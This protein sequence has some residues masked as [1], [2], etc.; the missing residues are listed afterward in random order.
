MIS[1]THKIGATTFVV[2]QVRSF[3]KYLWLK[4]LLALTHLRKY[5]SGID[6]IVYTR[7]DLSQ[8]QQQ[9]HSQQHHQSG[10]R[11]IPEVKGLPLVGTLFDLLAAGAAPKLHI[12]ID[13]RHGQYGDIFRERLGGTQDAIFVSSANLMRSVF[14]HEG[15]YPKHPLPDAWILYNQKHNC[16]RGLFFME[17]EEW[18]HNRRLLSRVLL[19]GH[20]NWMDWHVR[21]CTNR[22]ITKWKDDLANVKHSSGY[23]CMVIDNLEQQLYRWSIDVVIS[24]M[25]GSVA[26]EKA[27][28]T[29]HLAVTDFSKVVHKIFESSS[30]LMN[31]P[32][33][34][35]EYFRLKIWTDF[36][37][38]VEQAL[39]KGC[40]IIDMYLD[41][42][43]E[44]P[45]GL[46]AKL[47]EADTPMDMIK[48]LFVDLVIAAGDT[49]AYSSAWALYLLSKDSK[50]QQKI[51]EEHSHSH[52]DLP[53]V[54]GLVKETLR[55]YPVAPFIGRY[56]P[57]D[58]KIDK[59]HIKKDSLVLLSLYTAGRDPKHFPQPLEVMPE[60][61]LRDEH[62]G[63][64][65]GVYKPHA[66][67]P[68]AIGNRSCIGR[69]LAL[70]QMQHLIAEIT[71]HFKM[72]CENTT[73]IES[74]LR[75]VTVP[76][77]PL[78]LGLCPRIT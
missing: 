20:L 4:F 26:T 13:K 8:Q 39:N 18:F 9:L 10:P 33:K 14:Q 53:L 15:S 32:P 70:S 66:S 24:V 75:M 77:Q 38:S 17:G 41:L 76:N 51:Y 73:P 1:S 52:H 46:Y 67:L 43:T 56:L 59:Y 65:K 23:E 40:A 27:N 22:L 35:A 16:Q 54:R 12:Y 19:S 58:A 50:L 28:K 29:L 30:L 78:I 3:I 69:K 49:T 48:R 2:A 60:R 34:L 55:L 6:K 25:F 36:E 5:H 61:W 42:S 72:C 31:F 45:D 47:K 57:E 11:K 21:H 62:T 7:K 37:D 74:I 44:Y 64:Y 63:D 71:K 68:F